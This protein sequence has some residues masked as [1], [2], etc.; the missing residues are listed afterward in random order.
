MLDAQRADGGDGVT[1]EEDGVEDAERD[2]QLVERALHLR[3]PEHDDG[4][5]V[6]DEPE[7]AHDAGDEAREVPLP[8]LQDLKR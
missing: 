4:E 3:A 5:D 1:D 7:A 6:P 8:I 2:Q